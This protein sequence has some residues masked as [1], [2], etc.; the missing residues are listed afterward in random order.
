MTNAEANAIL[1]EM[2]DFDFEGFDEFE[3]EEDEIMFELDEEEELMQ[4]YADVQSLI[5]FGKGL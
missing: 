3:T 4:D 2:N 5:G 1:D